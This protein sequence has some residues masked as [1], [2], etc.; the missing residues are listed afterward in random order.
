MLKDIEG[1]LFDIDETIFQDDRLIEMVKEI[2]EVATGRKT[3]L[4]VGKPSCFM[5]EATL[6]FLRAVPKSCLIVG[7]RIESNIGFGRL[8]GMKTALVLICNASNVEADHLPQRIRLFLFS[9]VS[10]S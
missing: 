4:V 10:L 2:I 8:Q 1:I 9:E 7:D 5:A 3:K 6:D